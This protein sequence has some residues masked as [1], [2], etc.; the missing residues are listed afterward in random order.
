MVQ[1]I[2]PVVVVIVVIGIIVFTLRF[3]GRK[4]PATREEVHSKPETEKSRLL[5]EVPPPLTADIVNNT[6]ATICNTPFTKEG[7]VPVGMNSALLQHT[8]TRLSD[9]ALTKYTAI[10]LHNIVVDNATTFHAKYWSYETLLASAKEVPEF[11]AMLL[12]LKHAGVIDQLQGEAKRRQNG[13]INEPF[14]Y[15]L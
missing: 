12:M 7:I 8:L 3:K 9:P 5:D 15:N 1:N 14:T 11:L 6:I 13:K 2:V 4:A 10:R